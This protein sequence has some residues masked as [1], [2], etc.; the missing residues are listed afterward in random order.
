MLGLG[1]LVDKG[2]CGC[3]PYF[4]S[5]RSSCE[6]EGNYVLVLG[7][8]NSTKWKHGGWEMAYQVVTNAG[9]RLDVKAHHL[10]MVGTLD[11][12][13]RISLEVAQPG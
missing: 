9:V 1:R 12:T 11:M 5:A 4:F 3:D 13:D 8:P 7:G 2:D 6:R 10:V